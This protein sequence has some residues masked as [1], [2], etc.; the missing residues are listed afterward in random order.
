MKLFIFKPN[1]SYSGGAILVAA[2]SST[3]AYGLIALN[4]SCYAEATD[5]K[6]CTE[7]SSEI[8][9]TNLKEPTIII[10][11]FYIE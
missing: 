10:N 11:E 9:I 4:S 8:L 7:V 3:E 5:L 1:S 2:N 6:C